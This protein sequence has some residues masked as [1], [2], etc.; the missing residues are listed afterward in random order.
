MNL[1]KIVKVVINKFVGTGPSF[2]KKSI[3]QAVVSQMLRNTALMYSSDKEG[4]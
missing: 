2:C 1:K 3:Y 4:N